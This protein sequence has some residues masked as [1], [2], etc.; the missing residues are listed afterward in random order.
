MRSQFSYLACRYLR[1]RP[2]KK[3]LMR[4]APLSSLRQTVTPIT[5]KDGGAL[6]LRTWRQTAVGAAGGVRTVSRGEPDLT[7][8]LRTCQRLRLIAVKPIDLFSCQQISQMRRCPG[9][10]VTAI[11]THTECFGPRPG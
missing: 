3:S 8:T 6:A 1:R 2:Q 11:A 10:V 7:V 9:R 4:N 5:R